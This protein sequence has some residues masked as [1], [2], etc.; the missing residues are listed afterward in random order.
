MPEPDKTDATAFTRA[1][2]R[3][4]VACLLL[5]VLT[6]AVYW[7]V[8]TCEFISLDDPDYI[9]KNPHLQSG[10]NVEGVVWAFTTGRTGNWHP[11]TWLSHLLWTRG[12]LA[13]TQPGRT[14]SI[15]S[16]MPPTPCCYSW[17]SGSSPPLI[18]RALFVAALFVLHPPHVESVA[19]VSERKDVLSTLFFPLTL[20]VR[21]MTS[22]ARG[23]PRGGAEA[24]PWV[25]GR[26]ASARHWYWTALIASLSG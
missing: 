9:T 3:P 13:R 20:G 19:R 4:A 2:T 25:G 21:Q 7:P 1:L 16:F 24:V 22:G 14:L 26:A 6:L 15:W 18:G 17:C 10:L 5:A 11:L 8:S 23:Q 12:C